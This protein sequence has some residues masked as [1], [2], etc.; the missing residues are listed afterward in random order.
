MLRN[1]HHDVDAGFTEEQMLDEIR[2][3]A[4]EGWCNLKV[5]FTGRALLKWLLAYIDRKAKGAS[6]AP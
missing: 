6:D 3:Y 5:S 4:N 2:L 1:D